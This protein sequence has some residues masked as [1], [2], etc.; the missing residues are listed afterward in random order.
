MKRRQRVH[1]LVSAGGVVHR[2]KDGN[3]EIAI[4]GRN[5]PPLWA[6]PKGT[7]D[8]GE[9]Q[10]ETALREVREETGLEVDAEEFIDSI[11]YTFVRAFDGVR[12][13]KTVHF[14]LMAPTGGDISLHDHEF[15][16]V[17]WAPVD[18]ALN[19]LTYDNEVNIVQKGISMVPQERRDG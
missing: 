17:R 12:C 19:I 3:T 1:E 9:T 7:P 2:V 18:E 4:C 8:P 13:V 5:Y 16:T 15:D 14:Y 11:G 6:L 10:Q